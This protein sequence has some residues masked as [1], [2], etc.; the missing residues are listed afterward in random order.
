VTFL[1]LGCLDNEYIPIDEDGDPI[2][3]LLN[4]V[5]VELDT[6]MHEIKAKCY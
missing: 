6:Y 3:D 4:P 1:E 5:P 2:P